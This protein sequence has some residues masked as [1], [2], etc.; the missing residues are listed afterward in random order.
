M[1]RVGQQQNHVIG[2][3]INMFNGTEAAQIQGSGRAPER[4]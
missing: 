2:A 3:V 4:R 1:V